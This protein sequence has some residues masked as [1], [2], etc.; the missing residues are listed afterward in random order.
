LGQSQILQEINPH[1]A[2]QDA[3]EHE[4]KDGHVLEAEGSQLSIIAEAPSLLQEKAKKHPG[5]QASYQVAI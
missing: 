1:L 5:D 3:G 2:H 4:L